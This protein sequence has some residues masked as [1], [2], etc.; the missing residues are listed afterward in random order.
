M[1]TRP[2][3]IGSNQTISSVYTVAF[4]SELMAVQPEEKILEIGTGSG[5]QTAV[6][7]EMRAKVYSVERHRNLHKTSK[8]LLNRLNYQPNLFHGDGYLGLPQEAPFDKILVT[9]GATETSTSVT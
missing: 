6:L 2:F 8:H 3:P 9:C 7:E 1:K 5:Y 4:Q